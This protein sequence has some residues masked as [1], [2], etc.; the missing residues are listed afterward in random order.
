MLLGGWLRT[1]SAAGSVFQLHLC[2]FYE[3]IGSWLFFARFAAE[4]SMV[5]KMEPWHG[6]TSKS[7]CRTNSSSSLASMVKP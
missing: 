5:D 7:A 2:H 6:A 1:I 4:L 3:K